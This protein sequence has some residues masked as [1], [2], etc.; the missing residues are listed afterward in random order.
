MPKACKGSHKYSVTFSIVDPSI[1]LSTSVPFVWFCNSLDNLHMNFKVGDIIKIQGG[2]LQS[3]NSYPQLVGKDNCTSVTIFHR[4]DNFLT[5]WPSEPLTVIPPVQPT[6]GDDNESDDGRQA[7]AAAAVRLPYM[8]PAWEVT[9][10]GVADANGTEKMSRKERKALPPPPADRPPLMWPQEIHK[11]LY[12][13]NWVDR[14][15]TTHSFADSTQTATQHVTLHAMQMYLHR[16]ANSQAYDSLLPA[17]E[18]HPDGA[19]PAVPM[20]GGA[21][22]KCDLV[23]LVM[24]VLPAS[25]SVDGL[26][27][28]TV[29]DGTTNGMYTPSLQ[30]GKAIQ[31]ALDVPAVYDSADELAFYQEANKRTEATEASQAAHTQSSHVSTSS[32]AHVLTPMDASTELGAELNALLERD[33]ATRQ[34]AGSAVKNLAAEVAVNQHI[35]RCKPGMWIRIR[36]LYAL[37]NNTGPSG[38]GISVTACVKI[39]SH[40]CTLSPKYL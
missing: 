1:T 4:K 25:A 34:Y 23:C 37:T 38:A 19:Y 27:R 36:N 3:F 40:V 6:E 39:D 18:P 26:A 5:G 17:A 29:W 8:D 28:M 22:N 33:Y 2:F 14:Y 31:V 7:R 32:S 11:L 13:S 10:L 24:S 12:L 35:T 15:F 21:S 9:N 30:L 16:A 20:Q